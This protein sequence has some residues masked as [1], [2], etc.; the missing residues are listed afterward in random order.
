MNFSAVMK[1]Q[2]STLRE[3]PPVIS[4]FHADELKIKKVINKKP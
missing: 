3:H 1:R 2:T 4:R